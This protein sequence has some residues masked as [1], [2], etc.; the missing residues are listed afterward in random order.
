MCCV[1]DIF[2]RN[3]LKGLFYNGRNNAKCSKSLQN[4][5]LLLVTDKHKTLIL[6]HIKREYKKKTTR[7]KLLHWN[8]VFSMTFSRGI[9]NMVDQI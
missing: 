5:K 7:H 2:V 6:L 8:Q 3:F 9:K 1:P 4:K